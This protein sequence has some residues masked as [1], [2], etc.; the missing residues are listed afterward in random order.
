MDKSCTHFKYMHAHVSGMSSACHTNVL[1][2][3]MAQALL[4][5]NALL[6]MQ[7]SYDYC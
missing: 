2:T 4:A 7:T 3:Y 1:T 6:S 5:N